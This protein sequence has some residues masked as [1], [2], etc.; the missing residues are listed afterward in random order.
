MA[1]LHEFSDP[2]EPSSPDIRQ[3]RDQPNNEQEENDGLIVISA[4]DGVHSLDMLMWILRQGWLLVILFVFVGLDFISRYYFCNTY[5]CDL[6]S[7]WFCPFVINLL[8]RTVVAASGPLMLE[9]LIRAGEDVDLPFSKKFLTDWYRD[10][11]ITPGRTDTLLENAEDLAGEM[12]I[13]LKLTACQ[14]FGWS[15]GHALFMTAIC[16]MLSRHYP[17]LYQ[18]MS[19]SVVDIWW[20]CMNILADAAVSAVALVSMGSVIALYHCYRDLL[21]L[22]LKHNDHSTVAIKK[23]SDQMNRIIKRVTVLAFVVVLGFA[24]EVVMAAIFV[25]K[26]DHS[27]E[28]QVRVSDEHSLDILFLFVMMTVALASCPLM[29]TKV[30][31]VVL[32]IFLL[33]KTLY[34]IFWVKEQ[35]CLVNSIMEY[36]LIALT[37]AATL[38]LH[39]M[40]LWFSAIRRSEQTP[41]L[42]YIIHWTFALLLCICFILKSTFVS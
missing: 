30:F 21:R 9:H 4:L 12:K 35:S 13:N 39:E 31:A 27:S 5:G 3:R 17:D 20:S 42:C 41:Q 29:I 38:A 2:E 26:A 34:F 24:A 1:G 10:H 7:T 19:T 18:D 6:P 28:P 16:L 23:L 8:L 25:T 33:L 11:L 22:I 37:L 36:H 14:F 15:S 40:T 32:D